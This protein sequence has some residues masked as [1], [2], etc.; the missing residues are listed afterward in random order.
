M[1]CAL[2]VINEFGAV[3]LD[4]DLITRSSD[5]LVVEMMGG[6]LCCTIRGDL[7]RTLRDAPWR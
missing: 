4:H 2:V 1:R 3:S 7:L 6:C 5:D